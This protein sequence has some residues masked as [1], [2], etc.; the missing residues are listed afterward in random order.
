MPLLLLFV[1]GAS[2]AAGT[3]TLTCQS[4]SVAVTGTNS[5]V[6]FDRLVTASTGTVAVTGTNATL[7]LRYPLTASSGSVTITGTNAAVLFD[8]LVSASGGTIV[9]TGTDATLTYSAAGGPYVLT[10]DPGSLVITGTDAEFTHRYILD[11]NQDYFLVCEPGNVTISGLTPTTDVGALLVQSLAIH[12][13]A[14]ALRNAGE[15][16][17]AK[18]LEA[19]TLRQQAIA[20]DP[21]F[22]LSAWGEESQRLSPG[23]VRETESSGPSSPLAPQTHVGLMSFYESLDLEE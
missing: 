15:D 22:D 11:L 23:P 20:L 7:T 18:L 19:Y 16:A 3:Y 12:W 21:G 1:Q 4:G 17:T 13:E 14:L 10:C 2:V 5:A 9:L 6:L 8:R